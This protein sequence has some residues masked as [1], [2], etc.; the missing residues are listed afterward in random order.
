MGIDPSEFG[1]FIAVC[2]HN[3]ITGNISS[4]KRPFTLEAETT[5]VD[6]TFY[7]S[8]AELKD[9]RDRITDMLKQRADEVKKGICQDAFGADHDDSDIDDGSHDDFGDR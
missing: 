6:I 2:Y 4:F 3:D 8:H 1:C 7:L 5:G 9:L